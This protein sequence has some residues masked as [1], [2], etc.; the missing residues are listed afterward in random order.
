MPGHENFVKG[1]PDLLCNIRRNKKTRKPASAPE[2][3][4]PT[5]EGKT[6]ELGQ[7]PMQLHSQVESLSTCIRLMYERQKY[8]EQILSRLSN[9]GEHCSVHEIRCLRGAEAAVSLGSVRD[10][11]LP[12]LTTNAAISRGN[13]SSTVWQGDGGPR[14]D[15]CATRKTY[16]PFNGI[17]QWSVN[18]IPYDVKFCVVGILVLS[19]YSSEDLTP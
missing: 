6:G 12:Q 15:N 17:H 19:H 11:P 4:K 1:R 16:R 14:Y 13:C 3:V 7:Q 5:S 18:M 10:R 8:M 9:H 2:Y